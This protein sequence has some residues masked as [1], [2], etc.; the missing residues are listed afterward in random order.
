MEESGKGA[1]KAVNEELLHGATPL[2]PLWWRDFQ[3]GFTFLGSGALG[4]VSGHRSA[5]EVRS[6]KHLC[7]TVVNVLKQLMIAWN[8]TRCP[9]TLSKYIVLLPGDSQISL[10]V[11]IIWLKMQ[12]LTQ[13]V[14]AELIFCI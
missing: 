8:A 5:L 3:P 7:L 2:S 9:L 11:G 10:S 6:C 4:L 12:I 1:V 14:G 13:Q